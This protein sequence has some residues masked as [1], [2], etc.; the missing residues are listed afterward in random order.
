MPIFIYAKQMMTNL[1]HAARGFVYVLDAFYEKFIYCAVYTP[2][3]TRLKYSY[4]V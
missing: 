1:K 3:Y 4:T 2:A